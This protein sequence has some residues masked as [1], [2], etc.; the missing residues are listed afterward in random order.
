MT[1]IES[2]PNFLHGSMHAAIGGLQDDVAFAP[3]DVV[4]FLMHGWLDFFGRFGR[5]LIR[6]RGRWR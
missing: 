2:A 1:I 5:G 6:R 4:F 3:G